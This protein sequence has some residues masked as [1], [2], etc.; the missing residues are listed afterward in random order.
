MLSPYLTLTRCIRAAIS[1][2]NSQC[3]M[4]YSLSISKPFVVPKLPTSGERERERER[5]KRLKCTNAAILVTSGERIQHGG[6]SDGWAAIQDFR[7]E[8]NMLIH[9]KSLI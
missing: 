1:I 7:V 2:C 9:S 3:N 8:I 6:K 5:E 4:H